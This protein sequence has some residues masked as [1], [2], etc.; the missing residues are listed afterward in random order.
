M[1]YVQIHT[2]DTWCGRLVYGVVADI[3]IGLDLVCRNEI[4][5]N[6]LEMS[7]SVCAG[8]LSINC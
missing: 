4:A 3:A 5:R 2:K 6:F 1:T 8:A 7:Q